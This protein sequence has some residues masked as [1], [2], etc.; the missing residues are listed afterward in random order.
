MILMRAQKQMTAVH[1][2]KPA[3]TTAG[4]SQI[5]EKNKVFRNLNDL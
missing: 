5:W 3:L 2:S 4:K 1:A